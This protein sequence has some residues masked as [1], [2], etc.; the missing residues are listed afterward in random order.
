MASTNI[1]F[2]SMNELIAPSGC[3]NV[4]KSK[5][6]DLVA[7]GDLPPPTKIGRRSFWLN[8]DIYA[9]MDQVQKGAA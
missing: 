1:K 6:Y 9:F 2:L 7:K 4:S 3:L 5:V 8:A